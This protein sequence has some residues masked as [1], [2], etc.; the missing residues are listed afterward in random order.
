MALVEI[1]ERCGQAWDRSKRGKRTKAALGTVDMR[2]VPNAEWA[3]VTLRAEQARH[4]TD[5][6]LGPDRNPKEFHSTAGHVWSVLDTHA[7]NG[8]VLD[9]S[10]NRRSLTRQRFNRRRFP[11]Q[12]FMANPKESHSTADETHTYSTTSMTPR[13]AL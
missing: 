6:I 3:Q 12:R 11:Q 13:K 9:V 2:R 4:P 5:P 8:V 10:P 7:V 1:D